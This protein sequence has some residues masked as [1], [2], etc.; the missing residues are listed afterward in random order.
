MYSS[1]TGQ[2]Q[3]FNEQNSLA[4][5]FARRSCFE[6]CFLTPMN[7]RNSDTPQTYYSAEFN[8][9]NND[10][11]CGFNSHYAGIPYQ[12]Q[13]LPYS[14]W[15]SRNS[16]WRRENSQ[17]VGYA[18]RNYTTPDGQTCP[19]QPLRVVDETNTEKVVCP[20]LTS[21]SVQPQCKTCMTTV[22]QCERFKEVDPEA[23]KKCMEY[24]RMLHYDVITP[25]GSFIPMA[26]EMSNEGFAA[27]HAAVQ[28][29]SVACASCQV[30]YPS[31]NF[32]APQCRGPDYS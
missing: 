19:Q 29:C 6:P 22:F 11:N 9:V 18:P 27:Y 23:Y 13:A 2:C 12:N 32:K 20:I 21:L 24:K 4:A 5:P 3:S 15:D 30:N 25:D 10:K 8:V 17:V 28:R 26:V 16:I 1:R 7:D 14:G 31:Q